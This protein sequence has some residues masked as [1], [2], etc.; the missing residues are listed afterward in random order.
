MC[1][2]GGKCCREPV[3]QH[4]TKNYQKKVV[5]AAHLGVF[6]LTSALL[7]DTKATTNTRIGATKG[8]YQWVLGAISVPLVWQ[9]FPVTQVVNNASVFLLVQSSI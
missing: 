1:S 3:T 7:A 9:D 5:F 6:A 2:K 4:S 8:T